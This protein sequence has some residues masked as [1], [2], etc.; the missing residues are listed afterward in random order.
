MIDY[1]EGSGKQYHIGVKKGEVGKY[2]LLPGDPKRCKEIAKYFD[3]PKLIADSREFVT[4]TGEIDGVKVSVTSTGIGGPSAAI[5][6]EELKVCGAD[7]FIRVGTCGGMDL[8][9]K[10]GDMVI[11][12][13]AIRFE[14]TSK[15][16]APIEYP[17]VADFEIIT[18]LKNASDKLDINS[19]VG[20]VQSKDSFYG[21]HR[22]E[23]LPN[24]DELLSKWNAWCKLGCKASEM[25][26]AALFIVASY[27]KVRCGACFLAIANQEREKAGLSN[28]Q[29]HDTDEVIKVAIEAIRE[30]IKNDNK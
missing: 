23:T 2:V 20:V 12:S 16:Y 29:V 10:G 25:E 17:A 5:A 30:L 13:G 24:K 6:M 18:A 4:Y 22:P 15:E 28:I 26:S 11:A 14:G 7:T 1:A 3:N 27:L 19:H 8:D 21:Q 9:V